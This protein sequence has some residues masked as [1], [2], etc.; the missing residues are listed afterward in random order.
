[1]PWDRPRDKD[2]A[3][4]KTEGVRIIG[5]E[6][7]AE[8]IERG[9]V[10]PRRAEGELR[11]GDRPEAPPEDVRPAIRFPLPAE[12]SDAL[13]R[14]R[15]SPP[16]PE[17][18]LPPPAPLMPHWTDPPTGEVP[19]IVPEGVEEGDDDL[20]AW[21]SF[22]TSG[23]RWRDQASDWDDTDFDVADLSHDE[24]TRVGAL[25]TRDRP[26]PDDFLSF[27]SPALDAL[28]PFEPLAP[29]DEV[30]KR[31]R[32]VDPTAAPGPRPRR[33]HTPPSL[34]GGRDMQAATVTGVALVIVALVLFKIGP[35][36]AMLLVTAVV[37]LAASEL[38][39]ALRAGGY[40][41][42][43]LPGL[44]ATAGLVL[45][46]Y[47]RGESALPIVLALTTV[48][49]LLWFLLGPRT[50]HPTMQA[51]VTLLAVLH[52]G[53]LGS[54]AALILTLPNG[55]GVL[56]GVIVATASNDIG[57]LFIG[58]QAG[59]APLAPDISPN[60]TVEGVIG[61]GVVSLLITTVLLGPVLDLT[62][63]DTG[64]AAALALFVAVAA[65]LGDLCESMIKRD[66]GVKDM[67]SVLPG[68][69]GLL[70]RFDTLLFTL[71]VAFYLCRV[72]NIG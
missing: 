4:D 10:A 69:G 16:P 66:L 33:R 63:W 14:P 70:D 15:V 53:L 19:R 61:G 27:A 47:A 5:A 44:V 46:A 68:H 21:S 37:V 45:G 41:P 36:A 43:V 57:A 60:K 58:K 50:P 2:N 30:P 56:I 39:G 6:E 29:L 34:P 28:D 24:G 9:E 38:F 42:A 71:P 20:D 26:A 48:F 18:M 67:G 40:Q 52:V 1:M 7:A 8:A 55:I 54:F 64:S 32:A 49:T 12:E 11:Y 62:P 23:P 72:L 22:A 65:P 25:D 17:S 51:G 59:R 3:D 31:S 13:D 35:G